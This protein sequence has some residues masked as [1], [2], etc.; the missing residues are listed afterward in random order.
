M[1]SLAILLLLSGQVGYGKAGAATGVSVATAGLSNVLLARAVDRVG[2]RAVLAPAA[3]AYAVALS[4]L[5]AL[6]H[7]RY[8][9]QLLVCAVIGLVTPPVSSVSRG[10]WPRLLGI[11]RAQVIY[12]LE[13]TTQ[14]LV[15][16]AG[17]AMVALIAGLANARAAVV[18]T[19]ALGLV[20]AVSYVTAPPFAAA[21]R[22][23]PGR[24]RSVL[25]GTGVLWYTLVGVCLT[26][27]FN[28]TDIA[29]VD[30]VSGRKASASAGVVLAIWS[31]GS[32]VGGVGFGAAT[33]RTT[34]R[35]LARMVTVAAAGL[36][37]CAAAPDTVGLAV[38]LFVGGAAVAPSL[39]RLYTRI[40]SV[41]PGG[42]TTETFGWLAVGFLIGSSAGA[43][44]GGVSVD[45]L[46]ARPTFVLAGS[47]ALM[48]LA[49]IAVGSRRA[50][51]RT[52]DR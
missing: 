30:F 28:M 29:T 10:L 43:S 46:G 12:G 15:W 26:I 3:F 4:A 27:G 44:L 38:I 23:P 39:A 36:A 47:A 37:L 48:A 42:A 34:D 33:S 7:S 20:G 1:S 52:P 2:A 40:G 18:T 49:A 22:L 21:S 17:P 5:A 41:A 19:G 50:R 16:I 45:T 8:A 51:A 9:D 31:A 11:E 24:R 32:L 25:F 6:E 14:E 13:A 35:V